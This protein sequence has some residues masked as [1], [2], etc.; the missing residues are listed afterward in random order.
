MPAVKKPKLQ[1]RTFARHLDGMGPAAAREILRLKFT[2]AEL[3]RVRHLQEGCSDG[4]LS[5]AEKSE[6]VAYV[7]MGSLLTLMHIKART[8]LKRNASPS[9]RKSA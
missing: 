7:Q 6:L 4:T 2:P 5:R 8:A 3:R 9:T 1:L